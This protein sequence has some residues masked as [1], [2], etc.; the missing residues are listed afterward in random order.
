MNH[1][2]KRGWP[3]MAEDE[4]TPKLYAELARWWPLMSAPEDYADEAATFQQAIVEAAE[5]PPVT[6]LELGSG[7]GNNASHL[8]AHFRMTLVDRSAGM[9]GVS[10]A[11]N[12]ECEHI[13]GDMRDVRLGRVFDAVFVHDAVMYMSTEAELRA[14]METAFVHCRPGGVA[15]FV[16]DCVRETFVPTTEHGG[17]DGEGRGMR[18]L[19]WTVDADP[20]DSVYEVDYVY[21]LREADGSVRVEH[22]HHVE[23]LF[24]REVWLQLLGEVGFEVRVFTDGYGRD[25]FVAVRPG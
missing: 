15:L 25:V 4:A 10:R 17:H 2:S 20:S 21:M 1:K 12:P 9:L 6:L 14:A 19:E 24:A 22:D 8:K 7:G 23:G 3:I 18:Y 5:R 11:L 13:Q 16:P